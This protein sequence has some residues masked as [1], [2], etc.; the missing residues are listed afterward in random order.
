[1][2]DKDNL[3]GLFTMSDIERITQERSVQFKPARDARFISFVA[4]RSRPR[5]TPLANWTV[6]AF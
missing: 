1:V 4:R 5:A 3:R 6:N 2:D